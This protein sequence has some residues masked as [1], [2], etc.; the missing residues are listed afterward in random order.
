MANYFPLIVN[1]GNAT[2]YELPAGDNLDLASSNIVN[3]VSVTATS[4]I[5]GGNIVSVAAISGASLSVSGGITAGNIVPLANSTYNLGSN[6]LAW[7][8][9]YVAGNTIYLGTLQLKDIGSNTFAIYT[10]DGTTQANIDV[11]AIDVSSITQG[12]SAIGIAAPNGNAYIT[13]GG[14]ANVLLVT[15]TGISTPGTFTSTGN[16]TVGNLA[17]SG[18]IDT[19]DLAATGTIFAS[20]N[21]TGDNFFINDIPLY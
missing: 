3:A 13:V 10:S 16:A 9:L 12:N 14:N 4:N 5:N 15:S 11:G 1:S 21:V 2:I 18:I 20:G 19:G 17:T 7:N 8:S 6:T